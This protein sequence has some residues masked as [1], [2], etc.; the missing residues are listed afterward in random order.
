MPSHFYAPTRE[1]KFAF[2]IW[3]LQNRGRDPFGDVTRPELPALEC[4]RGLAQRNVYG[5]EFHDNDLIPFGA[6]A[7]ERDR[8]QQQIL[9]E[10]LVGA[11]DALLQ[12]ARFRAEL[13]ET[14]G[15]RAARD[16]VQGLAQRFACAVL[17]RPRG[18]ERRLESGQLV[19]CGHAHRATLTTFAGVPCTI[20]PAPN[21]AVDLDLGHLREPSFKVEPPAFHLHAW[22]P[23]EGFGELVTHQVPIGS[24][25]G[26]HPF[27]SADGKLL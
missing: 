8:I 12:I 7:A 27:F 20:C 25:D 22:F 24:F 15:P 26:P 13:V 1:D 21:H 14:V 19:A 11:L 16:L 2:G 17:S 5:F 6:P 18:G 3:C 10:R 23:G 4:I 9:C